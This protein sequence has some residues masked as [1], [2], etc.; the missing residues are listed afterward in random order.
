MKQVYLDNAATTP[1]HPKVFEKIKPFLTGNF[2]NPSSVHS[3]GRVVRVAIEEARETIAEFINSDPSEI[4]FTSGGTEANNFIIDGIATAEFL[5]STRN[6]LITSNAEHHSVLDKIQEMQKKDFKITS[7]NV[8]SETMIGVSSIEQFCNEKTSLVS[9]MHVNNETG[10]VNDIKQISDFLKPRNVFF[11]TDAVQSIG[12]IKVDVKSLGIDAL[13]GS[14][15]KIY[16][17]KGA[18]FAYVKG[19]TPLSSLL[20]GGSQER[21]RRGGTENVIGIIGLAEAVKLR[22]EVMEESIQHISKLRNRFIAGLQSFDSAGIFFN[23]GTNPLPYILSITLD[24]KKYRND[25]ESMIMFLDINGVAVSNG[26]ACTSGT[27]KASHVILASG[28]SPADAA[29]TIRISFGIQNTEEEIDFA[30]GIF[31]K[32]LKKFRV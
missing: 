25:S 27:V 13:S 11:H 3:Y 5:E 6:E 12:K 8:N 17:P 32:L 31:E 24:S 21:N 29:G 14:A 30:L 20:I 4:Y 2:G 10:S 26:S 23:G 16:A 15:H 18:G 22:K 1:V 9:I 19:G 28:Y 7:L